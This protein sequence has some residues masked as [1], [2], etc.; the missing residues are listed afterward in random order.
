M[1]YYIYDHE[2]GDYLLDENGYAIG[3]DPC[4]YKAEYG[5]EMDEE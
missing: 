5:D 4:W 2:A 1:I 3:P